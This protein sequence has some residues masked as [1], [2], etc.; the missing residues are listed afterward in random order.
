MNKDYY[1]IL[2]VSSDASFEEIQKAYRKLARRYHPDVNPGDKQAEEYMKRINEAYAVLSDES[3]RKVYDAEYT[4]KTYKTHNK[5]D[6]EQHKRQSEQQKNTRQ[7]YSG[8]D[9]E[10]K[11]MWDEMKKYYNSL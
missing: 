2:D 7:E 11:D 9:K 10:H 8:E 3:K 6:S 5:E 1:K 4:G